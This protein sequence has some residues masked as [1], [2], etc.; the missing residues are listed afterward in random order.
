MRSRGHCK[1]QLCKLR[2][3]LKDGISFICPLELI[4]HIQIVFWLA[5]SQTVVS[6]MNPNVRQQLQNLPAL[7][8]MVGASLNVRHQQFGDVCYEGV[9]ED[10]AHL[11][12]P[13]SSDK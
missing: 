2:A 8:F 13:S 11:A 7:R 10:K 5:F 1:F 3:A 4:P 12:V 6:D 9:K